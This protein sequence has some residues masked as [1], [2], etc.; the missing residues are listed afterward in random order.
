M[1]LLWIWASLKSCFRTKVLYSRLHL[2][3]TIAGEQCRPAIQEGRKSRA[4]TLEY[5][6]GPGHVNPMP[7]VSAAQY[8]ELFLETCEKLF[9]NQIDQ[10]AFE[11]Q[12]RAMFGLQVRHAIRLSSVIDVD[13]MVGAR[14]RSNH[15]LLTR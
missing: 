12:M 11:D 6:M 5:P 14:L 15:S 8:Y 13:E 9:D 4:R 10:N 7:G 1:S 3:K 2:F